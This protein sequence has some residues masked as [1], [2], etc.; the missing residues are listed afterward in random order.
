AITLCK[1]PIL[2]I[3]PHKFDFKPIS[4]FLGG[5]YKH[6]HLYDVIGILHEVSRKQ[7]A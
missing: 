4:D 7:T 5:S 1:T 2:N 6:D 3:A